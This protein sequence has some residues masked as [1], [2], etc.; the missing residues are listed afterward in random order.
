VPPSAV[1]GEVVGAVLPVAVALVAVPGS[2]YGYAMVNGVKVLA[3][4]N[5]RTIVYIQR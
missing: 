3:D 5:A 4:I 1:T 2:A